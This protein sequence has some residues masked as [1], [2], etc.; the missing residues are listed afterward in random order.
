MTLSMRINQLCIIKR[1]NR[2]AYYKQIIVVT[3]SALS[4]NHVVLLQMNKGAC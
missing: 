1:V 2:P 4:R 3:Y